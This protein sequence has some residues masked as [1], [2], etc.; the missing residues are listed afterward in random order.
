MHTNGLY[1]ALLCSLAAS[2]QAVVHEKLAAVPSSW[3]YLED[4]AD[5]NTISLSIALTRQNLDKLEAKL[6]ALATPGESQYGQWLDLE[7]INKE[8][9][10]SSADAVISWLRNANITQISQDGSLVNFAA[11]VATVNKLL[12]TTFAY[13]QSGSSTKLRTTQYSIPE[14]LVE[15]IDLISPTTYFGK[16][17]TKADLSQF[18]KPLSTHT[19][20]SSNSSCAELITLSCLK[21]MYNFGSY[22]PSASSGSKIGFGNFLNESASYSDLAAYEKYN[23]LPYQEFDVEL[24][25]GGVN[26]QNATTEELGEADLDVELIVGVS[27]PLPVTAFITGGLAPFIPDPDEPTEADDSNEPYLPYYE[28]LLSK[29]N[30]ALPQVISNSYGDDEQTVPE[31]YAKRVCNLIGLMG[32]RGI[33]IIESSGDE[34]IGSACRA[35]DGSNRPQFQPIFPATC[36]YV[37]AVGGTQSYGPEIAWTGSSG[38]FSNYFEQAWYQHDAVENYLS[39]HI[40]KET[41]KYYSQYA[42]FSGRAFPDV[43]THSYDPPYVV[44]EYNQTVGTGGTSAAAPVFAA[45]VGL[46]NDARLR[47]GKPAL[48][49]LNPLL[50]SK[51]ISKRFTDVTLGQSVGCDGIDPQSGETVPGAGII[52][53]ANWNATVG[54]DP[55]TG[56]GLPDFEKLKEAVLKY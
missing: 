49:Y 44:L 50:Y 5:G 56:L 14:S 33:S 52:P 7:D 39:H 41:K 31:Y 40:T 46:L 17:N 13:Y 27:H 35:G 10:V 30:S 47:A 18:T 48:G 9:P 51:D 38:G 3:S 28:Y 22:I 21:E 1:T 23:H 19:K 29:P 45:L 12:N 16:D 26:D 43:S 6:T 55:V 2:A 34:G 11:P 25:N 4:A 32:L 8:F 15:T 20:R 42:N 54:W 37:T 24:I 36:P 53:W